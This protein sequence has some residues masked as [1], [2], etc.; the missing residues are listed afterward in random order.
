MVYRAPKSMPSPG[1]AV[2]I[3]NFGQAQENLR[4]LGFQIHTLSP[5]QLH[6]STGQVE[7]DRLLQGAFRLVW[8]DTPGVAHGSGPNKLRPFW[9]SMQR[10]V[11]TARNVRVPLFICGPQSQVWLDPR[12]RNLVSDDLVCHSRHR[13]CHFGL[14]F[15]A[16]DPKPSMSQ[17]VMFST[18]EMPSVSPTLAC[19]VPRMSGIGPC[20]RTGWH[21]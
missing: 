5:S 9:T 20:L 7:Y 10:W 15:S 16:R 1:L 19:S 21:R 18:C 6:F 2:V 12:A 8:V 11:T 4:Q 13:L 3:S 17:F 14:K